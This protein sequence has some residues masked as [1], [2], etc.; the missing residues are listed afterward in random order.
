MRQILTGL[1]VVLICIARSA[2]AGEMREIVLSDGSIVSGEVLSLNKGIY[3]IRSGSLGTLRINESKVRVIR[4]RTSSQSA[5]A[6]RTA[7]NGE[8]QS[9]QGRIMN[10]Q[11]IM[12]LVRSLQDDPEFKKILED[13]DVLKAVNAGDIPALMANPK[14]SKLLNNSTVLEIQKKVK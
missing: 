2:P 13:P 8:L 11:E 12:G 1:A 9:L 10:D 14:V 3:T 6:E 7:T 5:D 4:P